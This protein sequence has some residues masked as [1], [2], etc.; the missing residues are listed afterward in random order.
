MLTKIEEMRKAMSRQRPGSATSR[1][2]FLTLVICVGLGI[3][4]LVTGSSNLGFLPWNIFLDPIIDF[5]Q[6]ETVFGII[7]F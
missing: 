4:T 1:L 2:A 6:V 5:S 3:R 7:P